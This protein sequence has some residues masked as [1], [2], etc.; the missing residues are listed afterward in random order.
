MANL[1]RPPP[2]HTP[3]ADPCKPYQSAMVLPLAAY[4]R[5]HNCHVTK[6]IFVDVMYEIKA[7]EVII[8][9]SRSRLISGIMLLSN[10]EVHV[11]CG[12]L[13]FCDE[14]CLNRQ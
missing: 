8:I 10:A 14:V 6:G 9:K 5:H 12:L 13:W 4:Y 3:F 2:L 1:N 7:T 11:S